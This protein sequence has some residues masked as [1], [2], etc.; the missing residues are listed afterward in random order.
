MDRR[1]RSKSPQCPRRSAPVPFPNK[2]DQ[3][4]SPQPRD[5]RATGR[6]ADGRATARRACPRCPRMPPR[7][8]SP[9]VRGDIDVGNH[10]RRATA[11]VITAPRTRGMPPRRHRNRAVVE[12]R[13]GR[14]GHDMPPARR[15][16]RLRAHTPQPQAK[17]PR[18][19]P[20]APPGKGGR[21][22]RF[23]A[24]GGAER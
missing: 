15:I 4:R 22:R 11:D 13:A 16:R 17:C 2:W 3:G 8:T 9:W 21:K 6:D 18:C 12:T 20:K 7:R 5:R 19:A 1:S 10:H 14:R 24:S 23:L